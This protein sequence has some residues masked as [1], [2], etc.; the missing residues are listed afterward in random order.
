MIPVEELKKGSIY[1]GETSL[2]RKILDFYRVRMGK[3]PY[4]VKSPVNSIVRYI[5]VA[6]DGSEVGSPYSCEGATFSKWAIEEVIN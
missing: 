4:K 5:R 1:M 6:E 3:R 2:N